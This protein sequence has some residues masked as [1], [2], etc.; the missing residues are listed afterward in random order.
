[1][2]IRMPTSESISKFFDVAIDALT[3]RKKLE[4]LY[5]AWIKKVPAVLICGASGVGKSQFIGSLNNYALAPIS[6]MHRTR[7]WVSKEISLEGSK[8]N[9]LDTP[10]Q[11][12]DETIRS[13]AQIHALRSG[14][15]GIINVVAYGFHE[16]T[17]LISDAAGETND[18]WEAN[19]SFLERSREVEAAAIDE[20]A[21]LA[22]DARW[23]ITLVN[24]ADLWWTPKEGEMVTD[25][26]SGESE[27]HKKLKPWDGKHIVLPYCSVI[28]PFF[29][30]V[31]S[32]G[33]LGDDRRLMYRDATFSA[34]QSLVEQGR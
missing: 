33:Y 31:P 5:N 12:N 2:E 13:R 7:M 18:S 25:Y 17:A 34:L 32:T 19:R 10:G 30:V 9:F 15:F 23:L 3:Q 4:K 21:H 28:K 20:W 8:Y 14:N 27:Y 1:M 6:R 24:K 29:D 26:Y 22:F 11:A 16:S